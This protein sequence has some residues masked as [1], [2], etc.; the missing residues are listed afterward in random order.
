MFWIP[1]G[2]RQPLGELR[3]KRIDD[4]PKVLRVLNDFIDLLIAIAR[5]LHNFHE[6]GKL[7]NIR[8]IR[9]EPLNLVI[10]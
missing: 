2:I 6:L 7:L 8:R 3:K 5:T 1:R 10:R 4:T 9:E